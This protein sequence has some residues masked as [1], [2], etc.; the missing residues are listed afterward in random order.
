[1]SDDY[2][3]KREDTEENSFTQELKARRIDKTTEMGSEVKYDNLVPLILAT[4]ME[5]MNHKNTMALMSK[6]IVVPIVNKLEEQISE[7]H[8]QIS[9]LHDE[10]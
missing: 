3:R 4:F 10:G 8:E 6:N 1:M 7:L 9:E 5:A 2:K